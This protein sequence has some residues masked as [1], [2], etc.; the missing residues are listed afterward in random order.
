[1][2]NAYMGWNLPGFRAITDTDRGN[3]EWF[4]WSSDSTGKKA[5]FTATFDCMLCYM[6]WDCGKVCRKTPTQLGE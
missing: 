4:G 1:M 3:S 6:G 2:H 5:Q